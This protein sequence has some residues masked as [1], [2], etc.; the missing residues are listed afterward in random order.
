MWK[1]TTPT[2]TAIQARRDR[3]VGSTTTPFNQFE[4]APGGFWENK[5][6]AVAADQVGYLVVYEGDSTGDPT[7][8]R[9]I[10]G[11]LW[12]PEALFLPLVVK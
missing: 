5:S 10:Y 12:W 4:V 6:P 2:G 7:V 11:R 9:R 1:Q 3:L 8:Y